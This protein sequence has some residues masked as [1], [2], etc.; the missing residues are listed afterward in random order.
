M[1]QQFEAVPLEG[2]PQSWSVGLNKFISVYADMSLPKALN[3]Q[4][5]L[6][7]TAR[8]AQN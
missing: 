3:V 4:I 5:P 6:A 7:R 2:R 1:F 8:V